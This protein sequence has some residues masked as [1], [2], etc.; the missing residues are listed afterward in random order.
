MNAALKK[1][2]GEDHGE[3]DI[4]NPEEAREVQIGTAILSALDEMSATMEP[5]SPLDTIRLLAEELIEMHGGTQMVP[6]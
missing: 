1:V 5:G 2:I 6:Q 3:V 4:A